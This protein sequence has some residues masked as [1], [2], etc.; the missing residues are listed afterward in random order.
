MSPPPHTSAATPAS[1][2]PLSTLSPHFIYSPEQ[3]FS[4]EITVFFL[5][6]LPCWSVSYRAWQLACLGRHCVPSSWHT[7]GA[8][9]VFNE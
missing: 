9:E 4:L 2:L 7:G 8:E 5:V 3:L 1:I 6:R